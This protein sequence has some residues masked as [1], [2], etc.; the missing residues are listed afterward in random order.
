MSTKHAETASSLAEEHHTQP[1]K[2]ELHASSVSTSGPPL[3]KE[4]VP[5]SSTAGIIYGFGRPVIRMMPLPMPPPMADVIQLDPGS[6][7]FYIVAHDWRQLWK[8]IY[9]QAAVR[10]ETL[11]VDEEDKLPKATLQTVLHFLEVSVQN[12]K[13]LVAHE[14]KLPD[15]SRRVVLYMA[16]RSSNT[17]DESFSV[18]TSLV[19]P[20]FPHPDLGRPLLHTR[21]TQVY[22][23][24]TRPFPMIPL[25]LPNFALYLSAAFDESCRAQDSRARLRMLVTGE[26]SPIMPPARSMESVGWFQ[27]LKA[28]LRLRRK[29][30]VKEEQGCILVTPYA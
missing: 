23:V 10:I 14:S 25:L 16:I 8:F 6:P 21:E 1:G 5:A 27:G 24:P 7:P 9:I 22:T 4:P 28:S 15:G 12:Q 30:V 19:P 3:Y 20:D 2:G 26:S 17:P 13:K 29:P 18:D 11:A